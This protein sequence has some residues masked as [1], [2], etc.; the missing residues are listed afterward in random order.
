MRLPAFPSLSRRSSRRTNVLLVLIVCI[1][2][3][4]SHGLLVGG[5]PR[6]NDSRL[7]RHEAKPDSSRPLDASRKRQKRRDRWRSL[8]P[9]QRRKLRRLH[10]QLKSL[11]PKKRRELLRRLRGLDDETRRVVIRRARGEV[12]EDWAGDPDR[13]AHRRMLRRFLRQKLTEDERRQLKSLRGAARK[14]RL[15]HLLARRCQELAKELPPHIALEIENLPPRKQARRIYRFKTRQ[16]FRSTFSENEERAQIRNLSLK[17]L[18]T[19]L[20]SGARPK[21][22][23]EASW[24]R[25]L[26]L[27][28]FERKSVLLWI[29]GVS[30]RSRK[31][32]NGK[33]RGDKR[34]RRPEGTR[35]RSRQP[36]N[37]PVPRRSQP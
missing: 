2:D 7:Q 11:P 17:R 28:R 25:W 32:S 14:E 19:I 34:R 20:D 8:P 37:P 16:T 10:Q 23:S 18:R 26:R 6:Q 9:E 27:K 1:G 5:T 33:A 24:N 13:V 21:G 12:N 29:A 31:A 4:V 36:Q 30:D 15:N 22:I 35:K 3:P